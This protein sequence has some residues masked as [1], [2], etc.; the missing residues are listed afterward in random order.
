MIPYTSETIPAVEASA[1]A[2][3][4]WPGWRAVSGRNNGVARAT[5]TPIGTLTNSTQRHDTHSVM[6]PPSTRPSDPPP[7]TT[8]V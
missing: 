1:P 6:T 4:K 2:T 5:S 7:I 3:S 8:A